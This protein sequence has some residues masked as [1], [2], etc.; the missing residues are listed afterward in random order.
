MKLKI[1]DLPKKNLNPPDFFAS[2]GRQDIDDGHSD[3][4]FNETK[5]PAVITLDIC[6]IKPMSFLIPSSAKY[7][8]KFGRN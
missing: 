6:D 4:I 8:P 7:Q 3:G 2:N 1:L 5:N